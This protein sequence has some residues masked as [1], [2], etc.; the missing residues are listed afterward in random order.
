[1]LGHV[2]LVVGVAGEREGRIRQREDV[3][4]M[5]EAMP[6][7]HVDAHAHGED[8]KARPHLLDFHAHGAGSLVFRPHG[9]RARLRDLVRVARHA[10]LPV[11]FA[12]TLFEERAD[13]LG[14]VGRGAGQALQ[15]ALEIQLLGERVGR[16]LGD[17]A[18]GETQRIRGRER[19]LA[20][21][22]CHLRLELVVVDHLPDQPPGLGL[23][24]R[25]RLGQHGESAGARRA[26]EARQCPGAAGVWDETDAGKGLQE[27]R[28]ARRKH[29]VAGERNVGAGAGGNA[30]DG[31][32]HRLF[33]RRDEAN[34][35]VV[36]LLEPVAAIGHD[37][38]AGRAGL[39]QVLT[40]AE[41]TSRSRQHDHPALRI[42]ARSFQRR[43]QLGVHPRGERVE[44]VGPVEGQSGDAT[45]LCNQDCLAAHLHSL[46][47]LIEQDRFRLNRLPA[48]AT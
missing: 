15:V 36:P 41:G 23:F 3:A 5:A 25:K 30:V 33:Q 34:E 12:R 20:R 9:V 17:G 21:H 13:A 4:A 44:L 47:D 16:G 26:D 48:N 28:A 2:A 31:G 38:V 27:A 32:D 10:L 46:P 1:M 22:R 43:P 24:G 11:N 40:G 45:A 6:V 39:G 35:R 37:A 29:Q 8:G 7:D 42:A 18:F 19:E 14:R